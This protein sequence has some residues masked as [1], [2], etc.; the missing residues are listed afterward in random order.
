MSAPAVC[1]ALLAATLLQAAATCGAAEPQLAK[2]HLPQGFSIELWAMVPNARGLALGKSNVVFVGSMGDGGVRAVPFDATTMRAGTP[3]LIARDLKLPLGVAYR[4]GALY[5]SAVSRILRF[6]DIESK[7]DAP[8]QPKEIVA[9]LPEETHH[10]GRY[11]AFGPDGMLYIGVGAP[12][13]ICEP[14]P[15]R[16]AAILRMAPDGTKREVFA[17]GVRNTV[18]FDWDLRTG[19][20][21]FTD[22]GRDWLGDDLPPDKINVAPRAGLNFG[23]PYCHGGDLADPEFGA[24]RPCSD[25]QPPAAKLGAHVA[26]LGIRFITGSQFP[27]SYRGRVIYAEHGSWN[28][29]E[30]SGYRLMTAAISGTRLSD[31][32]EFATGFLQGQTAWGRPVDLLQLPDGSLLVSDDYAGAIYR[33]RYG[34]KQ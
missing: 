21:W 14:D 18:G 12:C 1:R 33:I 5:V 23:Y 17:R 26:P 24:K 10:G 19:N 9:D 22:N 34:E 16:Y 32:K 2:I 6:D 3:K 30:K 28:R 13:N 25:F 27:A 7:L 31:L 29:S 15:N 8:P 4:D 11:I 20:L